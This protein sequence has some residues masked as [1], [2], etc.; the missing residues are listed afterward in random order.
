M[1]VA[2][3]NGRAAATSIAAASARHVALRHQ[4]R[5]RPIGCDGADAAGGRRHERCARRHHLHHRIWK[6]VDISRVVV[7]G[8]SDGDIGRRKQRRHVIVEHVAQELYGVADARRLRARARSDASRSPPPAMATRSRGWLRFNAAAASI[9]YSN[10]FF[11]TSRPTAKTSGTLS[12]TPSI[13]RPRARASASG[14]NRSLS[15]P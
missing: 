5:G 1:S 15:T 7:N 8:R 14:L 13:C 9:R 3:C 2:G 10:P 6:S 4:A 12:A 11:L